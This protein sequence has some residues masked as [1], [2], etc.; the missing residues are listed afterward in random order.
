MKNSLQNY[1]GLAQYPHRPPLAQYLQGVGLLYVLAWLLLA[2]LFLFFAFLL[3][4]ARQ[5]SPIVFLRTAG[6]GPAGQ[7]ALRGGHFAH[8]A[9]LA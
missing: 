5:K 4:T 7:A 3:L 1:G 9:P 2:L 8:N 6:K